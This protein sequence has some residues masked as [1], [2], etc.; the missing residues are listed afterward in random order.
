[1]IN[2]KYIKASDAFNLI[3]DF[4]G[5][6]DTKAAYRAF[7]KAGWA[8]RNMPAAIIT[9]EDCRHSILT[10]GGKNYCCVNEC[11]CLGYCGNAEPKGYA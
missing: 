3:T 6:A 4:A 11:A 2:D 10:E 5:T 8:I 7:W 9:C 1:M